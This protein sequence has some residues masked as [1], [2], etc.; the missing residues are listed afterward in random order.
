M[1]KGWPRVSDAGSGFRKSDA[2]PACRI[3]W[4]RSAAPSLKSERA[5]RYRSAAHTHWRSEA[6]APGR[7][8][9]DH[10]DRPSSD[11]PRSRRVTETDV[12]SALTYDG[13]LGDSL[14]YKTISPSKLP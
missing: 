5:N 6:G 8:V 11:L 7:S 2:I 1:R 3:S 12:K 14:S 4:H 9:V 10:R 13:V